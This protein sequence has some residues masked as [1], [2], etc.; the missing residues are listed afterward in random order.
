MIVSV[1]ILLFQVIFR[2]FLPVMPKEDKI[3]EGM[4][5]VRMFLLH[6][7]ISNRLGSPLECSLRPCCLKLRSFII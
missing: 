3:N 7:I 2:N 6:Y 4:D 1:S 5:L